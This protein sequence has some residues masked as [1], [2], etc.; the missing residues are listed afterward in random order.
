MVVDYFYL[1]PEKYYLATISG[2]FAAFLSV[3]GS[4][5]IMYVIVSRKRLGSVYHRIMMGISASDLMSSAATMLQLLLRP[6]KTGLP[7][8]MG[9]FRTCEAVASFFMYTMTSYVY[10]GILSFYFFLT[11]RRGWSPRHVAKYTE[12]W[13]HIIAWLPSTV[14]NT[15]GVALQVY[16]PL[17][18]LG[19]VCMLATYPADCTV[20]KNV[21]CIRGEPI[22]IVRILM[23]INVITAISVVIGITSTW[24]VYR[25]VC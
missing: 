11:I 5:S 23:A 13:I 8:A 2:F 19:G 12:P 25:A 1:S 6:A 4:V 9:N 7:M 17:L 18:V 24:L 10:S 22:Y 3:F 20:S 16:N 21:E 14:I 15:F